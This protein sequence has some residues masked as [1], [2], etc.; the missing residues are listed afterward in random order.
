MTN[1]GKGILTAEEWGEI[2]ATYGQRCAYCGK[3]DRNLTVDHVLPVSRGGS[4]E[5]GNIV[6]ACNKCNSAKNNR[7][8]EEW[9][10]IGGFPLRRV[11]RAS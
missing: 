2:L 5:A 1:T 9:V 6:P 8:P 11:E 7:T 10:A 3:E 4:H